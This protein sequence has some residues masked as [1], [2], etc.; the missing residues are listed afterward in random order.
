[1]GVVKKQGILNTLIVYIGIAI[2]FISLLVVQPQLLKP[3]EVGLIR[4]LLSFSSLLAAVFPL[5]APNI[6]VKYLPKFFDPSKRHHGFFGLVLL[7]PILGVLLGSVFLYFLKDWFLGL[8]SEKSPLF[9]DYFEWVLP[10]A[11]FITFIYTF[12]SYCN[13]VFK[14]V[15]PSLLNDIVNRLLLIAI[16][17]LY[18]FQFLDL[19]Q[20]VTAFVLIYFLQGFLL[21]I[22]ILWTGNPGFVPDI[23]YTNERVGLQSI[24]R[25]GFILT[26]TSVSS[27]SIKYLDSVFLG[28]QSLEAVGVYSV[29]AF[30]ALIIETP[31]NSLERIANS[32]IAHLLSE[33]NVEEIKKIYVTSSRY[34]MWLGGVLA[35]LVVVNIEDL[36]LLLPEAYR[37][38][39]IVT[40][41]VSMGAFV[42][43]A[44]GINYPILINSSK[45]IWGSFFLL[46]LLL[47][48][49]LGNWLLIDVYQMGIMGAA[50]AT[51]SSSVIYNLLKFLFIWKN[52]KM[53]P[54]NFVSVKILLIV[55]IGLSVGILIPSL[56]HPVLSILIRGSMCAIVLL[57]LTYILNILPEFHQKIPFL[58]NKLK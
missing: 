58:K 9:V 55:C 14:T 21:L 12:N 51:T 39:A 56:S 20:F 49:L 11:V 10:L 50:I 41:I 53:Q 16:I 32:K 54:F 31:L 19:N 17:V 1:M 52:F 26:F 23:N 57:S 37:S 40:V 24:I 34:L 38:G 47:L 43:M 46:V 48:S 44:T 6:N 45:Y 15:F 3:S 18:F 7:F 25:Y 27:I 30:I 5:G 2:G 29:A 35:C 4:I 42:N 13:A 36:L 28:K 22:Y 33:N 8:Y